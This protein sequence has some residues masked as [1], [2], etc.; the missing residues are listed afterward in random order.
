M[1]TIV[2]LALAAVALPAVAI[3]QTQLIKIADSTATTTAYTAGSSMHRMAVDGDGNWYA[4]FK[5]GSPLVLY[6]STDGGAT[7]KEIAQDTT[8]GNP[9]GQGIVADPSCDLLHIGFHAKVGANKEA[10]HHRIFDTKTGKWAGP[11]T[12]VY[13]GATATQDFRFAD[14][15]CTERG[16]VVVAF[17]SPSS[18]PTGFKNSAG[19]FC[20]L[21]KGQ[22][23]FSA[24]FQISTGGNGSGL[25]NQMQAIGE[26]VHCFFRYSSGGHNVA[27]RAFDTEKMAFVAGQAVVDG[28]KATPASPNITNY[29][30][31]AIDDEGTL[32]VMYGVGD[33][34]LSTMGAYKV[35]YSKK[36]YSSWTTLKVA[37]DPTV[38]GKKDTKHLSL[39]H[40]TGTEVHC[41]YGKQS[42]PDDLGKLY[43]RELVNGALSAER[44]LLT[45]PARTFHTIWGH[46]TQQSGAGYVGFV[47]DESNGSQR[48]MWFL[49]DSGKAGVTRHFAAGCQ[50]NRAELPVL[51]T[52]IAPE[53]GKFVPLFRLQMGQMP[54]N[55]AGAIFL[56]AT[57]L[58]NGIDLT[59]IGAAGCQVIMDPY[60]S[61][62]GF[63]TDANGN[64]FIP[65]NIPS[66]FAGANFRFQAFVLAP[67]ANG[68]GFLLTRGLTVRP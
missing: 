4:V 20:V 6:K 31:S 53:A 7:W 18:A 14:I 44:L 12:L 66:T 13:N 52:N 42:P 27:Y 19:Y 61:L 47:H 54:A 34:T 21:K 60:L 9:S 40:T 45:R 29:M 63:A 16:T 26:V 30:T 33:L 1:K 3:A 35:A 37:D 8:G 56:G 46:R 10:P 59:A 58:P 17:K 23:A 38:L 22:T 50:G 67:G 57:C 2:S 15:E 43:S 39:V 24:P 36:P 11:A 64:S 51:S 28:P 48:N 41:M 49:N 68:A 55:S 65:L 62:A 5:R 25:R 32:Y